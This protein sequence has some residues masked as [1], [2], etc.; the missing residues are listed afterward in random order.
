M[1]IIV[2]DNEKE[3]RIGLIK[4]DYKIMDHGFYL[5]FLLVFY[6]L[7]ISNGCK[8]GNEDGVESTSQ[9]GRQTVSTVVQQLIRGLSF[10]FLAQSGLWA[11]SIRNL[12][13]IG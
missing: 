13:I 8:W 12:W 11:K 5:K 4:N 10:S 9:A 1:I 3:V 7:I 2:S 6:V